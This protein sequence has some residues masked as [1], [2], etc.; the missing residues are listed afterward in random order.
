MDQSK[1]V[2]NVIPLFGRKNN[3]QQNLENK[4][5]EFSAE[6]NPIVACDSCGKHCDAIWYGNYEEY[7]IQ[8]GMQ[9]SITGGYAEFFDDI[10]NP[11]WELNVCHDCSLAMFRFFVASNKYAFLKHN[12]Q[13]SAHCSMSDKPCC[14]FSFP[15]NGEN[16]EQ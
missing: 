13:D 7:S 3:N 2:S 15:L 8:N 1:Q 5:N 14:E 9:V 4:S 16:V 10:D 12:Y 11:L 6:L